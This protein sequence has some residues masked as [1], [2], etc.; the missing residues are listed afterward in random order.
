[1][2]ESLTG[3]GVN[4]RHACRILG[5]S[6]SG[7]YAW[8]AGRPRRGRCGGS[9]WPARSSRSIKPPAD[10]RGAACHG[11]AALWPGIIVGHNA[12]ES[13]MREL[14][15]KGLPTRRLPKSAAS[16]RSSSLDLVALV[17]ARSSERAVAD[18]HHRAPDAGGQGLLLCGPG[19]LLPP[20]RRLVDRHA[21]R[22]RCWSP[23]R[24]GW[25]PASRAPRRAGHPFRPRG[26]IHLWAFNQRVRDAGLAPSMGAIGCLLR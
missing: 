23:M 15:I 22:P 25:L 26:P 19:R 8:R 10:L 6:E 11:R 2:I 3:Q 16:R 13:I 7:Y 17:R 9:G 12:V 21:P 1:M 4:V 24:S 14:G 18:R 20:G 5:V